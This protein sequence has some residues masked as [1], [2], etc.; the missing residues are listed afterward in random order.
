MIFTGLCFSSLRRS[1]E[2]PDASKIERGTGSQVAKGRKGSA[3]I[4]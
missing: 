4:S 2:K 1:T 3:E